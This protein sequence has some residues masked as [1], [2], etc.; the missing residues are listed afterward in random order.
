M[1]IFWIYSEQVFLFLHTGLRGGN[2]QKIKLLGFAW[3]LVQSKEIYQGVNPENFIQEFLYEQPHQIFV[4]FI[5]KHVLFQVKATFLMPNFEC[6]FHSGT[7]QYHYSYSWS[8]M[9]QIV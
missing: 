5:L 6:A 1:M 4:L 3:N 2:L 8:N 7:T 9:T